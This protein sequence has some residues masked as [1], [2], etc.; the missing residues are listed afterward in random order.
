MSD[1]AFTILGAGLA[2][3][4][5]LERELGAG[6]MATVYLA[7]DVRHHRKVALKLL[8][9]A[10]SIQSRPT[11]AVTGVREVGGDFVLANSGSQS[12]GL[13]DVGPDGRIVAAEQVSG[14]FQLILVRNWMA[15]LG[16]EQRQ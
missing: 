16:A 15:G 8:L 3:R 10:A 6:G 2:D 12:D 5:R 9:M 1:T 7:E 4:Y 14:S 11:L 13:Y